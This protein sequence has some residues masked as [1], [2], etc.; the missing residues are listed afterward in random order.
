[1]K[2]IILGFF[3][4]ILC[5]QLFSA[6]LIASDFGY[7]IELTV[8]H[9]QSPLYQLTLPPSVYA[10]VAYASLSDVRVF[11]PQGN[12][13]PAFISHP[14][15]HTTQKQYP[16]P[17]S[18][19]NNPKTDLAEKASLA[20][21]V[22]IQLAKTQMNIENPLVKNPNHWIYIID[23]KK[24][25]ATYLKTLILNWKMDKTISWMSAVQVYSSND[26]TQWTLQNTATIAQ[27]KQDNNLALH[28]MIPLNN[29]NKTHYLILKFT[30][31]PLNIHIRTMHILGSQQE[32][33][34]DKRQPINVTF[35]TKN[36]AYFFNSEGVY[37]ISQLRFA[38]ATPFVGKIKIY[39]RA[40]SQAPWKF[41]AKSTLFSFKKGNI[42][43][44]Q[45]SIEFPTDTNPY[46]K[47]TTNNEMPDLTNIQF[48][49]YPDTLKFVANTNGP[50][51]LAFGNYT[52]T[53]Q[54]DAAQELYSKLAMQQPDINQ[55]AAGSL[56]RVLG[57]VMLQSP[58]VPPSKLPYIL[59]AI[60]IIG[61][62]ILILMVTSLLR[63]LNS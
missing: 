27:F 19:I 31:L 16:V 42:S 43:I 5:S 6:S 54:T 25:P 26:L 60:L 3:C 4:L 40:N 30:N 10:H 15:V 56:T 36:N 11:S 46:W 59:W 44:N 50:F 1:M 51:T 41:V 23:L 18:V 20:L 2:K 17:F 22:N 21:H 49:Y 29:I 48:A 63:R 62:L 47:I 12:L 38:M 35:T 32:K 9:S 55:A 13:I 28:N 34:N 53:S 33:S 8:N 37:P 7:N 24:T 39:S 45:Q 57:N 52:L 58:A 61:I 14:K